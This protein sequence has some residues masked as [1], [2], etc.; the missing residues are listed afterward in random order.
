MYPSQ[1]SSFRFF[2]ET[3]KEQQKGEK[4]ALNMHFEQSVGL[5]LI[6][7]ILYAIVGI[8][9][10]EDGGEPSSKD[11][12]VVALGKFDALHIGHRELAIQASKVGTAFLLS[13]LGMAN[14]LDGNL[15][16][17]FQIDFSKVRSLNPHQFVEK[18]S[19]ELVVRG[20]VA[21]NRSLRI[22]EKYR[23]G[24]RAS[25]NGSDLIRLCEEYGM[26]AYI[27]RSLMDK[28]Q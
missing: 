17:E 1:S 15:G 19:K 22:A 18:L 7:L 16:I 13:F 25:G 3:E 14:C 11:C 8:S 6:S 23:F 2:K 4:K 5:M 9:Q 26:E 21:G 27:I 20:V 10:D 12:G 28:N 24:Y